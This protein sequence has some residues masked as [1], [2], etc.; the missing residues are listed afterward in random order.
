M[1]NSWQYKKSFLIGDQTD[2]PTDFGK[3]AVAFPL[4]G[5]GGDPTG[6]PIFQLWI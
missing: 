2:W 5:I 1:L 3:L 6:P 4:V